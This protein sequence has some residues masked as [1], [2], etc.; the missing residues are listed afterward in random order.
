MRKELQKPKSWRNLC[1]R[2]T[3]SKATEKSQKYEKTLNL[4]M[5]RLCVIVCMLVHVIYGHSLS[6]PWAPLLDTLSLFIFGGSCL[7]LEF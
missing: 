6:P 4:A 1:R 3:V 7:A 5:R 2:S